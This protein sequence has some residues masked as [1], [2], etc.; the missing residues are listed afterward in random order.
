MLGSLG[1]IG[2][3]RITRLA[4]GVTVGAWVGRSLG[5]DNF[6]RLQVALAWTSLLVVLA[7]L[8]LDTIL[9]REFATADRERSQRLFNTAFW[10]RLAGGGIGT[11]V[12]LFG[13]FTVS[14]H[15]LRNVLI[16]VAW[17]SSQPAGAITELWLQAT[18][19][20]ATAARTQLLVLVLSTSLRLTLIGMGATVVAFAWAYAFEAATSVLFFGLVGRRLGQVPRL[21]RIAWA[22]AGPLLRE[23][24]PMLV[25]VIAAAFYQK[26]DLLLAN[27]YC[28]LGD[29][30]HYGVAVRLTEAA[31]FLPVV[32]AAAAAPRLARA[33]AMDQQ[34]YRRAYDQY[35]ALAV[36]LGVMSAA[37]LA[38]AAPVI[39]PVLFGHRFDGAVL[40]LQL[41]AC[42][43]VF[44]SCEIARSMHLIQIGR[45]YDT[46]IAHLAGVVAAVTAGPL[47]I[48]HYG[49]LGA[50]LTSVIAMAV[51]GWLSCW[52]YKETRPI[53]LKMAALC[54]RPD[55]WARAIVDLRRGQFDYN[56]V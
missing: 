45:A 27:R 53:G 28:S 18:C 21:A 37:G 42:V 49:A 52:F 4:V 23:C 13:A 16:A 54:F 26:F 15:T 33:R 44:L 43:L 40:L 10:L 8:G 17:M 7:N 51:A 25:S 38:V 22:D 5:P 1:W 6:G 39:V 2:I 56:G 11:I 36:G 19:R 31:Y 30:G 9:H 35:L 48:R 47:L 32:L 34:T 24:L 3:E 14:D 41:R 29:I 55:A 20:N 50:A 12:L 46:V